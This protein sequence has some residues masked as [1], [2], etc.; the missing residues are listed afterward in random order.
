MES[1]LRPPDE[2]KTTF[3]FLLLW[4]GLHQLHQYLTLLNA[5]LCLPQ[6]VADSVCLWFGAAQR[7][8]RSLFAEDS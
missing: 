8:Y 3:T 2:S 4:F 1:C 6:P 7:V 5:P